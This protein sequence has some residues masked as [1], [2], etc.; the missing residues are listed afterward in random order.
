MNPESAYYF[1]WHAQIDNPVA[2]LDNAAQ[3]I[4]RDVDAFPYGIRRSAAALL[5]VLSVRA[6]RQCA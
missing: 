2:T 5:C 6:E 4:I 3:H 1:D